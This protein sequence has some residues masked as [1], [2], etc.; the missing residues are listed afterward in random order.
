[1]GPAGKVQG[2]GTESNWL[3]G[4]YEWLSWVVHTE[5]RIFLE[6]MARRKAGGHSSQQ[7]TI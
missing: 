1:M 3:L 5:N 2:S 4:Q 6:I 7:A